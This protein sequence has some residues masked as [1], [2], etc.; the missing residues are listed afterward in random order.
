MDRHQGKTSELSARVGLIAALAVVALAL[1]V[2]AP[3][4]A[5]TNPAAPVP[6]QADAIPPVVLDI[7]YATYH[8]E[9]NLD[10][11]PAIGAQG[12]T[13]VV[14]YVH[15]GSPQT[16]GDKDDVQQ[17]QLDIL[18]MMVTHGI[19]VISINYR[20]YPGFAYPAHRDDVA[21]AIQ[22]VR[23]NASTY[24]IDPERLVLWGQSAGS[25]ISGWVTYGDDL[26]D[27]LGT[28][29]EQISTRPLG[30]INFAALADWTLMIPTFPADF[31]GYEFLFQVPPAFLESVSIAQMVCNIPRD[32]TAPVCSRYA[33]HTGIPPYADPHDPGMM[34]SLHGM[35]RACYPDVAAESLQLRRVVNLP[36]KNNRLVVKWT[37]EVFGMG[38]VPVGQWKKD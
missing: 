23:F 21:R 5:A 19:T 38:G 1:V 12:P 11:Y 4:G 16:G 29:E 17:A 24:D 7:P 30:W 14:I 9:L 2:P 20:P 13:P 31:F 6:L 33:Q 36:E 27:P 25:I 26:A 32:Y 28:P 22:H 37:L 10:W 34:E 8:P 15:G 18:W 35:L 3:A